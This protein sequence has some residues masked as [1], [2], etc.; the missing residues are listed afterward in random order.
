MYSYIVVRNKRANP[1]LTIG[2]GS[3]SRPNRPGCL[4]KSNMRP[5]KLIQ[6]WKDEFKVE[7]GWYRYFRSYMRYLRADMDIWGYMWS[8]WGLIQGWGL[9]WGLLKLK[10][11]DLWTERANFGPW[12][13]DYMFKWVHWKPMGADL[14]FVG[15]DKQTD[16]PLNEQTQKYLFGALAQKACMMLKG[17]LHKG[18][19]VGNL[20]LMSV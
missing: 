8:I 3:H 19:R 9:L 6:S 4:E 7:E 10:W 2:Q 5:A 18:S 13:A 11:V 12:S 17:W 15:G 14:T 1:M 20:E 16:R